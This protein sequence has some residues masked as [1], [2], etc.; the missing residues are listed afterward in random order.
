MKLRWGILGAGSIARQ[1]AAGLRASATG[2]LAAVAARDPERAQAF[3]AEYGGRGV[4]SYESLLQEPDVDVVYIALPH[5]LHAE[6]TIWC[7][8]AGKAIL[9]EKPFTLSAREAEEALA[10][11]RKAGVFFMEAFMYRCHPQTIAIRRMLSEGRLGAPQMVAAEFGFNAS[12]DWN[13]FRTDRALGGGALMDV[14][15]YAVSFAR[16]VAGEEPVRSEYAARIGEAGYDESGAGCLLFP[17]GMSAHFGT[18]IHATLRND[19]WIHGSEAHL[20]VESPWHCSGKMAIYRHG[21]QEPEE[22]IDLS[23]GGAELYA[24]EA[25]AVAEYFPS[26]ECPHMS[27]RDTQGNMRALDALRDSAGLRFAGEVTA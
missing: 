21:E 25:D 11:V 26:G 10:E 18:A 3:A 12:R 16:M 1:F 8:R 5:H 20:H 13:N 23:T 14:G 2:E 4:Q 24:A 9:C 6:W 7:A 22:V 27:L 17:G 15:T 19:A